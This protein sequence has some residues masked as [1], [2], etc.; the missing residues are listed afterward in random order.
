MILEHGKTYLTVGC[1]QEVTVYT[2]GKGK[3]HQ[4]VEGLMYGV[5]DGKVKVWRKNGGTYTAKGG[6]HPLNLTE[7]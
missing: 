3:Y 2:S 4:P 7:K 1:R 5:L 6:Y